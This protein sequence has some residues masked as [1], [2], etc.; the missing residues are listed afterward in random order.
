MSILMVGPAVESVREYDERFDR[1]ICVTVLD[2]VTGK[3][4]VSDR[5]NCAYWWSEGNGGCDCNRGTLFDLDGNDPWLSLP[6]DYCCGSKRFIVI[7][8]DTSLYSLGEM[9]ADYPGKGVA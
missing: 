4:V 8:A 3:T 7:A 5:E 1:N 2:T 6:E 9:N